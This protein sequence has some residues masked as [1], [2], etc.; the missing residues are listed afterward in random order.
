VNHHPETPPLPSSFAAAEHP[1]HRP[2]D[3]DVQRIEGPSII[4]RFAR[5]FPDTAFRRSLLPASPLPVRPQMSVAFSFR[6][7][8]CGQR[9]CRLVRC[10]R[11]PCPTEESKVQP[12]RPKIPSPSPPSALYVLQPQT[13]KK[14]HTSTQQLNSAQAYAYHLRFA[15][16]P[17]SIRACRDAALQM[18]RAPVGYSGPLDGQQLHLSCSSRV[19]PLFPLIPP[20]TVSYW[21]MLV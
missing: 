10:V 11:S 1:T 3:F 15:Y 8:T 9:R 18:P 6:A 4:G 13:E 16:S 2:S 5:L 17:P 19:V 14:K 21:S 12:A 7:A 20:F